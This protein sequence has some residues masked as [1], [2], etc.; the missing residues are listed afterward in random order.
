MRDNHGRA[1]ARESAREDWLATREGLVIPGANDLLREAFDTGAEWAEGDC[2]AIHSREQ[3]EWAVE[4]ATGQRQLDDAGALMRE[5]AELLRGYENHHRVRAADYFDGTD[6]HKA[7]TA[8]AERNAL[9]A[10]RL[11]AWLDGDDRYPVSTRQTVSVKVEAAPP[12]NIDEGASLPADVRAAMSIR[13]EPGEDAV[14]AHAERRPVAERPNV[15]L[16]TKGPLADPQ[17]VEGLL[18]ASGQTDATH[19]LSLAKAGA[20]RLQTGDPRFD[21]AR[22]VCVNG[23]LYQPATEA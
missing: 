21:P 7:A 20:F 15:K 3:E 18:A 6:G 5:A 12:G 11:E 2:G 10:A 14:T 8:K 19:P 23:Y 22:P 17:V 1:C 13:R 16:V 9:M 4:R